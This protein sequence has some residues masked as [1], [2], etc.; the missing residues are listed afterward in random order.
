MMENPISVAVVVAGMMGADIALCFALQAKEVL[1]KDI[2]MAYAAAGKERIEKILKKWEK[3]GKIDSEK[4][5]KCFE[6]IFPR[7]DY[8]GFEEVDLVVEAVVEEV[9]IKQKTFE[10]L[11]DVCKQTCIF[12]TNTSS[13]P[14]TQL[15]GYTRRPDRFI[16]MHFFSPASIM[17]LVEVIPGV[18]TAQDTIQKTMNIAGEIGKEPIL[19]ADRAGFVVNRLLFAFFNEA[20]RMVDEGVARPE[21]IDKAIKLGLNHPLGIFEMQDLVGLDS[22]L[23]VSGILQ[24]EYGE[25]F[26][27]AP[28]L[29]RK[30]AAGHLGRKVKRG[31]FDY[32]R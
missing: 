29:K 13:I 31:W 27:P 32:S 20:W 4:S 9:G 21:D 12:A 23:A 18:D 5:R 11:D 8:A 1:L 10:E 6:L 22:A 2:R 14:I 26:R 19:T 16:G 17:K 28:M 25:R 30:V 15:A 3:K 7:E 24:E